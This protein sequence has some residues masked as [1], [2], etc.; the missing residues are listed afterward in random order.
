MGFWQGSVF[1]HPA[2][3][4][5]G[6]GGSLLVFWVGARGW[7]DPHRDMGTSQ[8][9]GAP[10]TIQ[11]LFGGSRPG[12]AAQYRSNWGMLV[13]GARWCWGR[14]ERSSSRTPKPPH[15]AQMNAGCDLLSP[16]FGCLRA[17]GQDKPVGWKTSQEALEGPA[18]S[19]VGAICSAWGIWGC[20][21]AKPSRWSP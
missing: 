3:A 5:P 10:G 7:G 1:S 14:L 17:G 9:M 21:K 8:C 6:N 20:L 4:E 12:A 2:L 11:T 18:H 15:L 13:E 19:L 16:Y